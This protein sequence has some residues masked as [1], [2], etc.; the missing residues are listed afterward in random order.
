MLTLISGTGTLKGTKATVKIGHGHAGRELG[1]FAGGITASQWGMHGNGR[2]GRP[3]IR[4][5]VCIIL[6]SVYTAHFFMEVLRSS[7]V[8]AARLLRDG[9]PCCESQIRGLLFPRFLRCT[10]VRGNS[11]HGSSRVPPLRGS[12]WR[13]TFAATPRRKSSRSV[14]ILNVNMFYLL[15]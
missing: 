10:S 7:F 3:V 6:I 1:T 9:G 2:D 15:I 13:S 11:F 4:A 14:A 8:V 5:L 12:P